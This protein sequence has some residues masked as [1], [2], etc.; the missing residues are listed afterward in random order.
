MNKRVI[1]IGP[2][3]VESKQNRTGFDLILLG[4]QTYY[5]P[6][7]TVQAMSGMSDSQHGRLL[8]VN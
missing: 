2:L 5:L 6:V 4:R 3:Q 8:N 7:S 1:S